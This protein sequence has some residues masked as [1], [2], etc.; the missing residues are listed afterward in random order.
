[1]P[2][3][4]LRLEALG[5]SEEADALAFMAPAVAAAEVTASTS[6]GRRFAFG[7]RSATAA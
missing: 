1:V 7:S 3:A 5:G 6:T 4:R 2:A